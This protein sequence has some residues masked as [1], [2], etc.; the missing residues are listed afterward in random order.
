MDTILQISWYLLLLLLLDINYITWYV[1]IG[2]SYS[3]AYNVT[4]GFKVSNIASLFIALTCYGVNVCPFH[5]A[6]FPT[7]PSID[8]GMNYTKNV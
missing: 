6:S 7:N 3:F 2:P 5:L 8:V 1:A 4:L